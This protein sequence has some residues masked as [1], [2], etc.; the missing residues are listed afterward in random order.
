MSIF[1]K[2][3]SGKSPVK[4]RALLHIGTPKTGTT[5]IQRSL[6]SQQEQ[7][8]DIEVPVGEGGNQHYLALLYQPYKRLP[9]GFK[10]MYADQEALEKAVG[11]LHEWFHKKLDAASDLVLSSEFLS[12]FNVQEITSLKEDLEK[13]GYVDIRVVVYVRD[14]SEYYVSSLQQLL[15]AS[16]KVSDP[17]SFKYDFRPII[18]K[19]RRVFGDVVQV[20]KYDRSVLKDECVVQDFFSHCC[21]FFGKNIEGVKSYKDNS[22]LSLESMYLLKGYREKYHGSDHNRFKPDSNLLISL[23]QDETVN[24]KRNKPKLLDSVAALL[25]STH[26]NDMMWLYKQYG[27]D[28]CKKRSKNSVDPAELGENPSL[29]DLFGPPDHDVLQDL[30]L[31]VIHRLASSD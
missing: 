15:K 12:K 13:S 23:M 9:R 22:G 2:S 29:T 21:D 19:F 24:Y 27:I 17:S 1:G 8:G 11:S 10:S 5:S 14:V 28:I 3:S 31:E 7:L 20:K 18:N 4:K 26:A 25:E 16:H 30:Q 6:F